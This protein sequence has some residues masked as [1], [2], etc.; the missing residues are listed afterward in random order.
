M[1]KIAGFYVPV[2][3]TRA[4]GIC[5]YYNHLNRNELYIIH[6]GFIIIYAYNKIYIDL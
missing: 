1:R 6:R 2:K 5:F 4:G 3:F